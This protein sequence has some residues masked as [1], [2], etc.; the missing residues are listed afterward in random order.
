[1]IYRLV[2]ENLKHRPVRT[3]LSAVF[4]GVQVTL[5]LTLVGLSV[6]TLG[7]MQKRS[8]GTG[9]DI[10]IRPPGSTVLGF[11]G[12]MPNGAKLEALVRRQPHV[13]QVTGELVQ[14]IGNF[15]SIAGIDLAEFT[16]MS[17]GFRYYEGGPFQ[18][19]DDLMVDTTYAR[20][21]HLH[22]G[23]TV[24][25]GGG[26]AWHVGAVVESGKLSQLFAQIGHLQDLYSATDQVSLILVQVDEPANVSSVLMGLQDLLE[27]YKVYP[28]QELTDAMSVNNVPLL[29]DFTRV[30][31]GIAIVVGF[32][33]VLLTM[34]TAVL[35]RTREI[36]I[37]KALGASPGYV[38]GILVRESIVLAVIGTIAGI[39]MTYGTYGL[40]QR[41]GP[42]MLEQAIVP[43]WWPWAALISLVGATLGSIYPGLKAA[44]QDAIEALSYD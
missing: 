21:A 32:L 11:T 6:G 24:T 2:W 10:F 25:L 36:G 29:R 35:E 14:S 17:G 43:D 4:I 9:A 13:K 38:L 27:D 44:R 1:L 22:A 18:R 26:T 39:L 23:S 7:E 40:M 33:V 37:L 34:Y 19:P 20:A 31:V 41:F 30:V 16:S 42:P 8:R 12:N 3:L 15:Q 28:L 5:I